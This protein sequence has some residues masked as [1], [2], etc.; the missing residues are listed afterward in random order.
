MLHSFRESYYA[1]RVPNSVRITTTTTIITNWC[2]VMELETFEQ[3]NLQQFIH[4]GLTA[5]RALKYSVLLH[6]STMPSV[7][8]RLQHLIV[9]CS[10]NTGGMNVQPAELEVD[11][12]PIFL[13]RLVIPYG[14]REGVLKALGKMERNGIIARVTSSA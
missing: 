2:H 6:T 3:L 4:L 9:T 12:E 14:Q 5:I 1:V 8:T 10:N 13:K 7:H 11:G